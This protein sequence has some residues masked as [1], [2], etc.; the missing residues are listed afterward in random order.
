MTTKKTALELMNPSDEELAAG[1]LAAND[2]VDHMKRMG[3]AST[4]FEIIDERGKW[5]V[6]VELLPQSKAIH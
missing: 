3:A 6:T 2:L 5:R 4:S 1:E